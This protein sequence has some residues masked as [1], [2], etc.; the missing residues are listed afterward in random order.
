M[1]RLNRES[2]N[3]IAVLLFI[4]A[5]AASQFT[6]PSDVRGDCQ[7][8]PDGIYPTGHC[9]TFFLECSGGRTIK[10]NCSNGLWFN[11]QSLQCDYREQIVACQETFS[12]IGREDGVYSEGC[13]SLFWY[14]RAGQ[15]LHSSCPTGTFFNVE[16]RKCDY[17]SNIGACGGESKTSS[18]TTRRSTRVTSTMMTPTESSLQMERDSTEVP[19]G[20]TYPTYAPR[21]RISGTVSKTPLAESSA[22]TACAGKED[23]S[24]AI[25]MCSAQYVLC[26]AGTGE[27]MSCQEGLF[28]NEAKSACD[29]PLN[30]IGCNKVNVVES[31]TAATVSSVYKG[32]LPSSDSSSSLPIPR[33][34]IDFDCS[35]RTDGSY[36]RGCIADFYQCVAGVAYHSKCQDGLVFDDLTKACDYPEICSAPHTTVHDSS[37]QYFDTPSTA[38][39]VAAE[40]T[41]FDCSSRVDGLYS[42][43]CVQTYYTCSSGATHVSQCPIGLVFDGVTQNCDYMEKCGQPRPL[44]E[45][46]PYHKGSPSHETQINIQPSFDC[47]SR[48]DGGYG[49]TCS[50]EFVQCVSGIAYS[51]KCPVDLVFI[52]KIGACDYPEKC[53]EGERNSTSVDTAWTTPSTTT[54]TTVQPETPTLPLINYD[55]LNREDGLYS[56]GCSRIFVHC[57][58]GITLTQLCPDYLV[59]VQ[60]LSR[61]DFPS[62]CD[63]SPSEISQSTSSPYN[64]SMDNIGTTSMKADTVSSHKDEQSG[65]LIDCTTLPDGLY[66]SGCTSA[67]VQCAS[68]S[69]YPLQCPD[70]LVFD[71]RVS[72]CVWSSECSS[73]STD[74]PIVSIPVRPSDAP[75]AVFEMYEKEETTIDAPLPQMNKGGTLCTGT[76]RRTM[77]KCSSGFVQCIG[78][79]LIARRCPGQSLFDEK[80]GLCVYDLEEC[81]MDVNIID[82]EVSTVPVEVP[83]IVQQ[84][85]QEAT[86]SS[87]GYGTEAVQ[88]TSS[89]QEET[90]YQNGGY[91]QVSP[92]GQQSYQT[93]YQQSPP[94]QYE[95]AYPP[96]NGQYEYQDVSSYPSY[97][98][99]DD[100]L[101][102]SPSIPSSSEC[103]IGSFR[104]V[105]ACSSSFD[106]CSP[107]ALQWI[108]K[109]CGKSHRFDSSTT[110]C[111][112][113]FEVRECDE[114]LSS[115]IPPPAQSPPLSVYSNPTTSF[116]R[117]AHSGK[118][119]HQH[120]VVDSFSGGYQ[121]GRMGSN[122]FVAVGNTGTF[123][124]EDGFRWIGS[125]W[126]EGGN[127]RREHRHQNDGGY[128]IVSGN[129]FGAGRHN[130][131]LDDEWNGRKER[132]GSGKWSSLRE[133][134]GKRVK[135]VVDEFKG[136]VS[137]F[138]APLEVVNPFAVK[139]G[140]GHRR[141][142]RGRKNCHGERKHRRRE[143]REEDEEECEE[144][145]PKNRPTLNVEKNYDDGGEIVDG[146]EGESREEN[147]EE[148]REEIGEGVEKPSETIEEDEETGDALRGEEEENEE[149]DGEDNEN[150]NTEV[151]ETN[152][153]NDEKALEES[154]EEKEN[155]K[156]ID[157]EILPD[158]VNEDNE[159]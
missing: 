8:K 52:E 65:I 98:S 137:H 150:M 13:S 141:R 89:N 103:S 42:D 17:R 7:D 26:W 14:C 76:G 108:R 156:E 132:R 82:E 22:G 134:R 27:V 60:S 77:G 55:C 127:G 83:A 140:D 91:K 25:S 135:N 106:F 153:E 56:I 138:D 15:L 53:H 68:S 119:H 64:P 51:Q 85:E 1:G 58:S 143:E 34:P 38:T 39:P 112:P 114:P 80:I 126:N 61:C 10:Q 105:S 74:L 113:I 18:T 120:N 75:S 54:S 23:G 149:E 131:V 5:S 33:Q 115:Y 104:R 2:R 94:P 11:P 128:V 102:L 148:E 117:V 79:K 146:M 97:S 9:S 93:Q 48:V 139:R 123:Y 96:Q 36:S 46:T 118:E 88:S 50:H 87:I 84:S 129:P 157:L 90:M 66:S 107:T 24:H 145:E 72:K 130:T 45:S 63:G 116:D 152:V 124:A 44:D 136:H 142:G 155:E 158:F 47:S 59:F 133:M 21:Q 122:P 101:P 78:G 154:G 49:T 30:V 31:P 67:F 70:E 109:A 62:N 4:V 125:T 19:Y 81:E 111:R 144:K 110:K 99:F 73:T 121:S 71:K 6:S 43:G 95:T 57:A 40:P 20:H 151:D 32:A 16:S 35:S 159:K 92:I 100:S 12:C 29:Y 3:G 69:A 41:S 28:F 37:T 147:R 86:T